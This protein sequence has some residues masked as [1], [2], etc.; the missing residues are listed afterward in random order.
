VTPSARSVPLVL[1]AG[2]MLG[3]VVARRLERSFPDVVAATRAE[4]DVTDR[5]RLEAEIERLRPTILV[6]CAA[7]TDVDGCEVDPGRARRVN[8]EGAENAARAAAACGC[9]LIQISTDFVFDGRSSRPYGEDDATGPLSEYGRSKLEGERRVAAACADHLIVRTAWLYGSGRGNFV[10]AIRDR[11]REGSALKV[12]ND[13]YGSPTSVADLAE[14]IAQLL[15]TGHRGIVHFV[16]AGVCSRYELAGAILAIL[17]GPAPPLRPISTD[18]AG[19]LA[20][21]PAH[22]ALDT[23]LFHRLTGT[24]PRPWREALEEYLAGRGEADGVAADA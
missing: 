19:R 15:S 7:Y 24:V 20:V 9:R 4:I 11:A 18:D 17:G 13:Q 16:N 12:V 3:R 21:R 2:G 23:T 8:A 22:S 10:D 5:F 14:A 6:N 1:G